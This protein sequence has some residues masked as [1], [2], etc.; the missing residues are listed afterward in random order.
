MLALHDYVAEQAGR[1][2]AGGYIARIEAACAALST[3][4]ERGT[5]QP[6]LGAG[7]RTIGFERRITIVFRRI[8][9]DIQILRVL[10][11][12]RDLQTLLGPNPDSD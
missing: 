10:Y 2:V 4:P 8:D 11:G 12:G 5:L 7:V 9:L 6:G 3:F 1:G